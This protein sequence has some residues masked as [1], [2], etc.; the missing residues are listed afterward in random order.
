MSALRESKRPSDPPRVLAVVS[1]THAQMAYTREAVRM[2]EDLEVDVVVHCGDIGSPA[3]VELFDGWPTHF[4]FGNVDYEE[5]PLRAAIAS[6][7]QTCHERFGSI[8]LAG[9]K[10]AFLHGDDQRRLRQTIDSGDWDLVCYGH[11]HQAASR[12]QGTTLALNPGALYRAHPHTFA[13][14]SLPGLAVTSIPI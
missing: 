8:E 6:A 2:F 10:I 5:E 14:V 9:R 7:G 13:V 12:R 11:T 1:D 3:I 4:V